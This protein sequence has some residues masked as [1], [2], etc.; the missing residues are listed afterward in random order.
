MKI[1]KWNKLIGQERVK[2]V[3]GGAFGNGTLGHAYLFCGE[4]GV[5]KFAA[6]VDLAMAALCKHEEARPCG[7]CPAC[8]KISA[9]SHPD[10]HVLMPLVLQAEHKKE[11]GLSEQGWKFA[12]ESAGQRI[13]DPYKL[14]VYDT[15]PNIPVDWIR[16]ANHAIQRGGTEG[17]FNVAVIDGV[18][19]M[20]KSSVN[21]MLKTLEEPPPG[22]VMILLTDNPHNVL[23]TVISR[24]QII[25][26][27]TLPPGVIASELSARF[28]VG[29]DDPR[30]AL[31][32]AGGSLGAA[33]EEFE[34]PREE[35]FRAAA[36]LW[37][38][39]QNGDWAAAAQAAE[40]ISNGKDAFSECQKVI[41]CLMELLRFAFLSQSGAS[42]N[43]FNLT[44]FHKLKL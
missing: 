12:A 4:R 28:K 10:F 19:T 13:A 1:L 7:A 24:C 35:Y 36:G 41:R 32:A 23:Q 27:A 3:I 26:F 2:S 25:R 31:A 21:A 39:C 6:A 43:Y 37:N 9:Y 16:E 38:D 29:A 11:S 33:I 34:E 42:I 40:R 17:A 8:K 5:G 22:S 15:I 20:N 18:D 30:V 14:P 44:G